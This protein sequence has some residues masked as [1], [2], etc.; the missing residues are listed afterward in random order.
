MRR[1]LLAL[2]LFSLPVSLLAAESPSIDCST[3][4]LATIADD[5]VYKNV[6]DQAKSVARDVCLSIS[7]TLILD[8]SERQQGVDADLQRSLTEFAAFSAQ[9]LTDDFGNSSTIKLNDNVTEMKQQLASIDLATGK[10][11]EFR[12]SPTEQG[13]E[14][15]FTTGEKPRFQFPEDSPECK[16]VRSANKNCEAVFEDF[17]VAFNA[18]RKAYDKVVT[19]TNKVL[20]NAI[21]R[22]WDDF[23]DVSKSQTALEVWLT[24]L[25][26]SKHFK[27]DH[28][29]GPPSSQIIALHPQLVYEYVDGA[30]DGD[31]AEFGVA[32]E[33]LGINFWNKKMPFGF[34]VASVY[35]DRVSIAD[36]RTGVMLHL[37][38]KYSIGW[39]YR[40][41]EN[42]VY[43]SLDLLTLFQSKRQQYDRYIQ[44]YKGY[45]E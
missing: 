23:L 7:K 12:T 42:S 3:F 37:D 20:L 4:E 31:N 17:A 1:L 24:T 8:S 5:N 29:V 35:T 13:F 28:I 11:P 19:S 14:G 9:A 15:Y 16:Q 21:N 27:K 2:L 25:W 30:V 39:G 10:F 18:Y 40:D 44:Q 6:Y 33:W 22:G 43:F 32:V 45:L 26:H 34:S 36:I 38:N 41:G